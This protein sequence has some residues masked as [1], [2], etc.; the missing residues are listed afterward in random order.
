MTACRSD[1]RELTVTG[2]VAWKVTRL[3]SCEGVKLRYSVPSMP[4]ILMNIT[5]S[6]GLQSLSSIDRHM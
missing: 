5:L 2:G 6:A 3:G 1:S 4:A